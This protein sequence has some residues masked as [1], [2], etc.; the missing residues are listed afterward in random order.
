MDQYTAPSLLTVAVK[1]DE[2]RP[3]CGVRPVLLPHG[4]EMETDSH[5]QCAR[6]GH[7]CDYSPRLSFRDDTQRIMERMPD[8]STIGSVV[9]DRRFFFFLAYFAIPCRL[10]MLTKGFSRGNSVLSI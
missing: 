2:A 4:T 10:S 6:L 3:T 9:W 1:C 8:V 5:Q 7:Q